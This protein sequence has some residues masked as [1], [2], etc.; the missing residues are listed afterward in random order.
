MPVPSPRASQ[1]ASQDRGRERNRQ[2]HRKRVLSD[3]KS[4]RKAVEEKENAALCEW[5]QEIAGPKQGFQRAAQ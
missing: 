4:G 1:A 5:G 2:R 3:W